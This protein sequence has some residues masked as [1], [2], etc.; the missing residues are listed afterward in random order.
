MLPGIRLTIS[1]AAATLGPYRPVIRVQAL[2][3]QTGHSGACRNFIH[4]CILDVVLFLGGIRS[5][6]V[7]SNISAAKFT[8][9]D[10]VGCGWMV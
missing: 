2:L 8:V 1:T 6:I 3:P 4:P 10:R 7:P 5:V 9:S